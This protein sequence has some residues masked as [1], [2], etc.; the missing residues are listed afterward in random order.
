MKRP[1]RFTRVLIIGLLVFVVTGAAYAFTAS[2]TMP[3]ATHAGDGNV[4]ISNYTVSN[5][6][7]G[8]G[9]AS[10][11]DIASVTFDLDAAALPANVK[12]QLVSGGPWYDSCVGTVANTHFVCTSG[13][14]NTTVNAANSL[15]IVATE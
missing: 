8:L 3:T 13:T 7:Y 14:T 9:T 10:P 11:A 12:A 6:T 2:N 15:T 4:A 1:F 5:V